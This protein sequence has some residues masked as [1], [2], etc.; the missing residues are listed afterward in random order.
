M[1]G[2][3]MAI[4]LQGL[5]RL[6]GIQANCHGRRGGIASGRPFDVETFLG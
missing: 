4:K 1:D 2:I 3:Q 5:A 6:A